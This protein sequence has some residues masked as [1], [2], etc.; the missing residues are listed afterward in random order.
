MFFTKGHAYIDLNRCNYN[1]GNLKMRQ[2]TKRYS[3]QPLP[4]ILGFCS[5]L[6]GSGSLIYFTGFLFWGPAVS[7][8]IDLSVEHALIL[9]V[10]LSLLFF[11]Q[12][13]IMVREGFKQK[14]L[15]SVP[16]DWQAAVFSLTS[17]L[18]LILVVF[19]W[20]STDMILFDIPD[21]VKILV[22]FVVLL[23]MAGF[24]WGSYSLSGFDPFGARP[25]KNHSAEKPVLKF[26]GPYK[27]MRHPLYFFVLVLIWS[28]SVFG[29]T[30]DRLL[31]NIIWTVWI[32]L[33]TWLEEKDLV[34][35]FGDQYLKYQ[36]QVS[37]IIP[38][39]WLDRKTRR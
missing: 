5:R 34:K 21:P 11:C 2:N 12:H 16:S 29:P 28:S 17:G 19:F 20:Q 13:S 30:L 35:L 37:M 25:H 6:I 33:G 7:I 24:Y 39:K 31:F 27:Y 26:R 23:T 38:L 18:C 14:I 8:N 1:M 32:F 3:Q 9:D 10:C 22:I 4:Q 36:K 15:S